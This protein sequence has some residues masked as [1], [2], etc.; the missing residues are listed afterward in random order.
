MEGKEGE[1]GRGERS[2]GGREG[3][4]GMKRN[5]SKVEGRGRDNEEGERERKGKN[6]NND[7]LIYSENIEMQ[8]KGKGKVE[9]ICKSNSWPLCSS[10]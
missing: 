5:G 6:K 1:R 10:P 9:G 3:S 8:I 7:K 2:K 4:G